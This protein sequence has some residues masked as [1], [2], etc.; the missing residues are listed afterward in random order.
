MKAR[1]IFIALAAALALA[2]CSGPNQQTYQGWVE[3]DLI[4]VSPYEMGRV[5]TLAVREGDVVEAGTPLFTVDADIQ[6]ADVEVQ[7]A[8]V[9]NAK[10]EFERAKSLRETGTG[11]QKALDDAEAALRTAEARLASSQ[12]RLTRRQV[13]SPAAGTIQQI[14]YRPGETVPAGRPVLALLPPGNIKLRFFVPETVL[15]KIALGDNVRVRCDGCKEDIPARVTFI[16]RSSE[17]TP[18]VIYSLEER[19]KLVYMVEAR[20]EQTQ[21]LRVGQPIS[22]TLELKK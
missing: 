8:A 20:T 13:F 18:P 19:N 4:F 1:P 16:S 21:N 15:P 3:A 6:Q 12:S 11:T 22:V 9:I 10:I 2:A 5:E 7:K 14:Y 17:F